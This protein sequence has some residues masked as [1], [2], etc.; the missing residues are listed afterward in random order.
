M[1]PQLVII[2]L[3]IQCITFYNRS[4]GNSIILFFQFEA[5]TESPVGDVF[6]SAYLA[7]GYIA[8]SDNH[9]FQIDVYVNTEENY[10]F[11]ITD[12]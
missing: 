12:R 9:D 2:T 8:S 7:K 4:F 11:F 5:F 3:Q 10:T 1:C 6:V